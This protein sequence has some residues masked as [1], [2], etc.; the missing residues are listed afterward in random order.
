MNYQGNQKCTKIDQNRNCTTQSVKVTYN[1]YLH[2]N[3]GTGCMLRYKTIHHKKTHNRIQRSRENWMQP[4]ETDSEMVLGDKE[5]SKKDWTLD[6]CS[7]IEP[8]RLR[9]AVCVCVCVCASVC[10]CV[11][12]R[13]HWPHKTETQVNLKIKSLIPKAAV[14]PGLPVF[15]FVNSLICSLLRLLEVNVYLACQ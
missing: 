8:K 1:D 12:V 9:P 13:T 5:E 6:E 2:R 3:L 14:N 4:E 7:I 15:E 10:V 11:C